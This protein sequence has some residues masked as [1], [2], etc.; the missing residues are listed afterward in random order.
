MKLSTEKYDGDIT[1]RSWTGPK[2][3]LIVEVERFCLLERNKSIEV[4]DLAMKL[5]RFFKIEGNIQQLNTG[6]VDQMEHRGKMDRCSLGFWY[7]F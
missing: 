4:P 5:L 7:S 3:F 1:F 2:L 6:Y